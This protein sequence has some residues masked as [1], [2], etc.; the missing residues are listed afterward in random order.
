LAFARYQLK[1]AILENVLGDNYTEDDR[2]AALEFFGG[3]AFCGGVEAPRNDHLVPV[4]DQGD[5]VRQNV[6][7]ACAKCDDSKGQKDFRRWMRETTSKCSLRQ[8]GFTDAQIEERIQ[9]I[10]QWQAGY[11]PKTDEQLFRKELGRYRLILEKMDNLIEE[12]QQLVNDVSSESTKLTVPEAHPW[13]PL[14]HDYKVADSIRQ[15][16]LDRYIAPARARG[17]KF[18]VIRAGDIHQQMKFHQQHP[19]VCQVLRDNEL[20]KIADIKL[21]STEGPPIANTCFTYQL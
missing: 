12:A 19:N 20:L 21:V 3:C 2:D 18:I 17:E 13:Q 1:R 10:E 4:I 11:E 7:P 14:T 15:F 8:R 9:R 5:F 6:V 16:V